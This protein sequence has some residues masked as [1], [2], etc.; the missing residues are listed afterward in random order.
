M[1]RKSTLILLITFLILIVGVFI[2]QRSR[3]QLGIEGTPTATNVNLID[4]DGNS[5]SGLRISALKGG[6]LYVELDDEGNWLFVNRPGETVDEEQ[7]KSAIAILEGVTALAEI[8]QPPDLNIIGLDPAN[9]R[10]VIDFEDGSEQVFLIGS[11]TPTQ[12]GYYVLKEDGSIIIVNGSNV[13]TLVGLLTDLPIVKTPTP[14][15][16]IVI[17]ETPQP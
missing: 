5:I 10:V 4:N 14:S 1:I 12:S 9:Y 16:S 2:W 17:T 13:D 3:E 7:L 11:E 15:Q 8:D 6:L